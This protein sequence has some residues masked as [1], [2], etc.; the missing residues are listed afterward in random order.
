MKTGFVRLVRLRRSMSPRLPVLLLAAALTSCATTPERRPAASS[1]NPAR[2]MEL[3]TPLRTVP[4]VDLARYMG[5]WRVIANI[6]YFAERGKVDTIEGY[7][8]RPDGKID[9]TFTFR[10]GTFDA[11]QKSYHFT[12]EVTNPQSNA[13][14]RVKFLPLVKVA[15]LIIDLDPD[16]QWTVV[17][18]PSRK[19][20]WIMAREKTMPDA[21][22][23]SILTRLGE[24]GYDPAK[25]EKV[26]Q[27]PPQTGGQ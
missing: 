18:H 15:Y 25:F 22:Y 21:T 16:Y 5:D 23:R 4:K 3:S 24:Q 12:A 13:E 6:P 14:W 2:P 17:G 7:R 8:L 27:V 1:P 10:K 26:P 9:N 20:G 11:P 19:Y